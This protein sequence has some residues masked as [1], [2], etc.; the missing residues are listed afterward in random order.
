[1][2]VNSKL[3]QK[4]FLSLINEMENDLHDVFIIIRN[5]V[6]EL[7]DTAVQKQMSIEE[8]E[9]EIDK[10]LISD[11]SNEINIRQIIDE[12]VSDDK[13]EEI[14]IVENSNNNLKRVQKA[15][16]K[17]ETS[18]DIARRKE[19]LSKKYS[20]SWKGKK[21]EKLISNIIAENYAKISSNVLKADKKKFFLNL[22]TS[23]PKRNVEKT[24]VLPPVKEVINK[25]PT[26]I[27]AA[28]KGKLL[29]KTIRDLLKNDIKQTLLS[30]NITTKRGYVNKNI[31]KKLQ[32]KIIETFQNY[33]ERNKK[34][35]VP[36]NVRN[37]AVTE[38]RFVINNIRHEYVK[39]ISNEVKN[40]FLIKKKWIQNKSLSKNPRESHTKLHNSRAILLNEQFNVNG[41][42]AYSP[43]DVRLPASETIGCSCELKYIFVPKTKKN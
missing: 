30:E 21:Y 37:I 28:E 33:T 40:N 39:R 20:D 29:T 5:D 41:H 16:N 4:K 27:K 38:S 1:M 3:K 10:L 6:L 26:I 19:R 24:I 23:M 25:S 35:K 14:T 9:I 22:K 11:S 36:N 31:Q 13:A 18:Y 17:Y 2:I 12:N 34:F 7:I 8:L 43:H 42:L 15:K 32:K